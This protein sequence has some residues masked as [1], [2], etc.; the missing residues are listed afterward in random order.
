MIVAMH[1]GISRVIHNGVDIRKN[2]YIMD[3]ITDSD[4]NMNYTQDIPAC[5]AAIKHS[6]ISRVI[7]MF[8]VTRFFYKH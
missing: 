6:L 3:I 4:T 8:A 5:I 2:V 7:N 1:D